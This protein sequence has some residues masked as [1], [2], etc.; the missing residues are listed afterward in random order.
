MK[1]LRW[2]RAIFSAA[3]GLPSEGFVFR[4][5]SGVEMVAKLVVFPAEFGSAV[6]L[7]LMALVT[8]GLVVEGLP[9]ALHLASAVAHPWLYTAIAGFALCAGIVQAG[10][11][12]H[13]GVW[14]G[15]RLWSCRLSM[16]ASL[17]LL[18]VF[19][20][21]RFYGSMVAAAILLLLNWTSTVSWEAR[22]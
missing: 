11:L 4:P 21:V 6:G 12:W 14:P 5:S 16:A 19:I 7:I 2:G 10:G 9:G 13:S 17:A 22:R 1:N 15:A 3:T 18:M 8:P 20:P